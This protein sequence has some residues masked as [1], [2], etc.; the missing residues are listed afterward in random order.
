MERG[1]DM[2]GHGCRLEGRGIGLIF[3]QYTTDLL[4]AT[5]LYCQGIACVLVDL[6]TARKI[7]IYGDATRYV[8]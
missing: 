7:A 1:R 2:K 6:D 3:A 8:Q 5:T 4:G